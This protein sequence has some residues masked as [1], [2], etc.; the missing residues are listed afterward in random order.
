MSTDGA[1]LENDGRISPTAEEAASA[2][3]DWYA[4]LG[5]D[6]V[7]AD[8]GTD[9]FAK[10][11]VAPGEE[12]RMA[13]REAARQDPGERAAQ[14]PAGRAPPTAAAAASAVPSGAREPA[15]IAAGQQG[16]RSV[17]PPDA[18]ETAAR[19]IA[20]GAP[21]L[22]ALAAAI[23]NF[24][25]CSL[26]VTATKTCVYRGAETARIAVIGEAPGRDEDLAGRPFVGRAGQLLDKMLSAIGLDESNTHI[27]NV[28]YWR[29]PGNRAPTEQEALACR[30]FLERQIALVDPDIILLMGGSAAKQILE[31]NDGIM[32]TRGKW[33][34]VSF[35]GRTR[36]AISSLHPAYLLRT[37]A[38]K[39]MA[40]KDLLAVKKRLD[41]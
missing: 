2:L 41:V 8:T 10:A 33:K 34:T 7:V 19:R 12:L 32:R 4:A 1:N 15:R 39:H 18:I 25:G 9:W 17:P 23:A 38:A 22:A 27:T 40:W 29:P 3:L 26:K 11:G 6:A 24:D 13:L 30:P 36:Q 21:D 14:R 31:T 16:G 35:G 37:P 20:E 5:A 28:V